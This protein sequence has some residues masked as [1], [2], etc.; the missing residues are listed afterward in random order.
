MDTPTLKSKNGQMVND[1]FKL[2]NK[3]RKGDES[4]V[5]LLMNLWHPEGIFEFAG[6]PPV[7]GTYKGAVAIRTLYKNRLNSSGMKLKLDMGKQKLREVSLGIVETEVTHLREKDNQIIAGWRTT[8]GTEDGRGFDVAGSHM[9]T[10]EDGKIKNL[11]LN[12]SPKAD[13]SQM[14]S[15]SLNDL[16]VQD[17]GRLSLAAWPVV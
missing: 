17:I 14:K 12:I 16:S 3:L 10:I 11:R 8:I 1:Y 2:I 13:T 9:F 7:I 15:L 5:E 6:T 4:S